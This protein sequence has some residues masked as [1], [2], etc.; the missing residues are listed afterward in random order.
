VEDAPV[1]VARERE[2]VVLDGA[3]ERMREEA[4]D[5]Q[6]VATGL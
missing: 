4:V 2:Q 6:D 3:A 1:G 5:D